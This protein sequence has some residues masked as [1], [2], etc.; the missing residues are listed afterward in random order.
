MQI[1]LEPDDPLLAEELIRAVYGVTP[2]FLVPI[3]ALEVYQ[4]I[5]GSVHAI[6]MNICQKGLP[7]LTVHMLIPDHP[8]L[9][10]GQLVYLY[11]KGKVVGQTSPMTRDALHGDYF[12]VHLLSIEF[13]EAK[14][15]MNE[16][17][18]A[19]KLSVVSNGA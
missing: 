2:S 12:M 18:E 17:V 5:V 7:F 10:E 9:D 6:L 16:W 14:L 8:E 4:P 13:A 19:P 11:T 3:V 15:I 1:G